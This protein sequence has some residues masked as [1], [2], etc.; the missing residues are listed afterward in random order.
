[1]LVCQCKEDIARKINLQHVLKVRDTRKI[2]DTT[3]GVATPTSHRLRC[4]LRGRSTGRCLDDRERSKS[5]KAGPLLG[6]ETAGGLSCM[7]VL[8]YVISRRRR[9]R[10]SQGRGRKTGW[11]GP[12]MMTGRDSRIEGVGGIMK[13]DLCIRSIGPR[14]RHTSARSRSGA[15]RR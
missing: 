10:S 2:A 13:G 4:G 15:R 14:G 9:T 11:R 7:G 5:M 8:S 6:L 1:V 3:C 12:H